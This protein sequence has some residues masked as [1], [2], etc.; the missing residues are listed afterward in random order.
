LAYRFAV[1]EEKRDL[2]KKLS[3][4][5]MLTGKSLAITLNSPFHLIANR[6][7]VSHGRPPRD[8]NRTWDAL[9]A[10][11]VDWLVSSQTG[12]AIT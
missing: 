5:R 12:T 11:L 3:S 10:T 7:S 6:F 4:N 9:I 8:T 2:V 1:D